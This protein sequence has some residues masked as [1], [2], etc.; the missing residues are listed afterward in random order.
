[1][2]KKKLVILIVLGFVIQGCATPYQGPIPDLNLKG[3][4]GQEEF[5]RFKFKEGFFNNGANSFLMG[6]DEK[7]YTLDSL[8][9]VIDGVSPN[10]TR[11]LE[12][13]STLQDFGIASSAFFWTSLIVL[14]LTPSQQTANVAGAVALVSLG[15]EIGFAIAYTSKMADVAEEYN[16]ELQKKLS[17]TVTMNVKF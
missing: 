15:S 4:Q 6:Q 2:K 12:T 8:R 1:M 11:S 9:P 3:P 14:I 7:R 13:A 5:N 10:S 17:P 16:H